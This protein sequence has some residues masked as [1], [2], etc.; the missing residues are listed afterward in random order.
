MNDLSKLLPSGSSS[1]RFS[2]TRSARTAR[3]PRS[4][5]A[6]GLRL[7]EYYNENERQESTIKLLAL[8]IR[9][10]FVPNGFSPDRVKE[11][12]LPRN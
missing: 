9:Y 3:A 11:A 5:L 1:T 2:S 8:T 4:Y 10:S 12:I 7:A 6:L